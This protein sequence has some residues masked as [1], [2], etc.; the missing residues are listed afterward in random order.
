MSLSL[1]LTFGVGMGSTPTEDPA[2]G[3][4]GLFQFLIGNELILYF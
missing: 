3:N 4:G 2:A 1:L